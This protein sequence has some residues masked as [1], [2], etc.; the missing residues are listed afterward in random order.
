MLAR[1]DALALAATAALVPAAAAQTAP[2]PG[3]LDVVAEYEMQG[4]GV[5]CSHD[6]RIFVCF[7]RWEQEMPIS[8]G[9]LKNGQFSPYPNAEWNAWR[10]AKHLDPKT[11][12]ICVQS[13]TV[14]PQ[15]YLWILDP[16]AP[17]T[18]FI[19]PDG[20][21]LLKVDLKTDKVVQAIHFG[22]DTAPQGS[23]LNDVRVS[24]DG[25]WAYLT[26]SGASS[27][28]L[29]VDLRSGRIQRLLKDDPRTQPEPGVN[30]VV[31]GRAVVKPNGQKPQFGADSLALSVDGKTVYWQAL[32]GTKLYATDA[33]SMQAGRPS[34]RVVGPADIA[35]GYWMARDGRLYVTHPEDNSVRLRHADGTLQVVAQDPRLLW[36]D[37]MAEMPDGAILVT[38]SDIQDMAQWHDKGSTRTQPYRLF[39]FQPPKA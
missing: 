31:N 26:D 30:V 22:M 19:I 15:G 25:R 4:T 37:S 10:N 11:H 14:D 27:A 18:E 9:E 21:K 13:V 29:V 33:A 7:P 1:R 5:A 6:G 34:T 36:P 28:L 16:A 38:A 35:D 23:Y 32:V 8:V 17:A 20:P 24:A 3:A 39:R 12:L 2:A